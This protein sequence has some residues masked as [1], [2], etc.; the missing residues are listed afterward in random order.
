MARERFE[1]W[2]PRERV[3]PTVRRR[4]HRRGSGHI[5]QEGDLAEAVASPQRAAGR[6]LELAVCDDI[7][8][9]AGVALAYD[10][11]TANAGNRDQCTSSTVR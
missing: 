3:Q 5:A 1:E 2:L 7:E 11:I 10:A 9:I 4:R 6:N 8:A